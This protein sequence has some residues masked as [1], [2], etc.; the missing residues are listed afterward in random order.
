M[1]SDDTDAPIPYQLT[2]AADWPVGWV[3]VVCPCGALIGGYDG[4][5]PPTVLE[6]GHQCRPGVPARTTLLYP[7]EMAFHG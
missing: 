4:D 3:K 1:N 7:S 2:E 6:I 5:K